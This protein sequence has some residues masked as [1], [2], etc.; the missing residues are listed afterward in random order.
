MLLNHCYV[1][2]ILFLFLYLKSMLKLAEFQ[3]LNESCHIFCIKNWKVL[4]MT[5]KVGMI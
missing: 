1:N 3:N 2:K 5:Q 4:I